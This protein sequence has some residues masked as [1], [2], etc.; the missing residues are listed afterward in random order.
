MA[1][2]TREELFSQN[3]RLCA[4]ADTMLTETGLGELLHEAGY[5]LVGSYTMG[6]MTW[7]DLDFERTEEP[8]DWNRHWSWGQKLAQNA[9]IWRLAC[10]DGYRDPRNPDS[11]GGLYWG[12]RL[13]YPKGGSIWKL[14]LWTARLAEFED[15][16]RKRA[17][18]MSKLT[19]DTRY[20][21]LEIKNAVWDSAE[22]LNS[23]LSV[24]IYEAVLDYGVRGLD[25]FRVWWEK[26]YRK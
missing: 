5:E 16:W 21:I 19:D 1:M 24:H 10:I 18:W 26:Y 12:L 4:E 14:D 23:L 11:E 25:E 2:I 22:Y 3:A 6:T 7:C 13:D 15:G 9:W 20:H 17:A 8:P